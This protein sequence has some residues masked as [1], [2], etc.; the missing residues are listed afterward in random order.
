MSR[1]NI[2]VFEDTP[3]RIDALRERLS[4]VALH[5]YGCEIGLSVCMNADT[6]E[7]DLIATW[8]LILV[9]DDLGNGLRGDNVINDIVKILN[10]DI[11]SMNL[12]IIYYSSG[13]THQELQSRSRR[14]GL[15]RI[16]C[17]SSDDLFDSIIGRIRTLYAAH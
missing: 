16:P 3:E 17:M 4:T 13:T 8:H 5:E 10:Q 6:L 2:L 7:Q 12:P 15:G 9:D 14:F 11:D 1:F